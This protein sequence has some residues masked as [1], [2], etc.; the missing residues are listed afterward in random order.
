MTVPYQSKKVTEGQQAYSLCDEARLATLQIQM[1]PNSVLKIFGTCGPKNRVPNPQIS[2]RHK[3]NPQ[4]IAEKCPK[5]V[6]YRQVENKGD[7]A[8]YIEV[9]PYRASALRFELDLKSKP[10][11]KEEKQEHKKGDPK[12]LEEV[13]WMQL[14]EMAKN[15]G[16]ANPHS[17]KKDELIKH[18]RD[19]IPNIPESV[20]INNQLNAN[21]PAKPS[22]QSDDINSCAY[23]YVV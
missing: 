17:A 2:P 20:Y 11:A 1:P 10:E 18:I 19:F 8:D 16:M 4:K 15:A 13:S 9:M 22:N 7:M 14:K 3:Q 6:L 12:T 21:R 5:F 23:I